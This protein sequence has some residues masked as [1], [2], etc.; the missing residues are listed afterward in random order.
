MT[1]TRRRA[2]R[3]GAAALLIAA[4]AGLALGE[5]L[6][7]RYQP[8]QG[9]AVTYRGE[10]S[11][12]AVL[13]VMGEKTTQ[14]IGVAM[15]FTDRIRAVRGEN[16]VL[17]RAFRKM[18]LA[19][20]GQKEDAPDEVLKQERSYTLDPQGVV[21]AATTGDAN[22]NPL[23]GMGF[24][25]MSL[26]LLP[27]VIVP[28]PEA[29]VSVGDSWDASESL[30]YLGEESQGLKV[31]ATTTLVSVYESEGMQVALTQTEWSAEGDLEA[32]VETRGQ[33]PAGAP[34]IPMP[35]VSVKFSGAVL[36]SSRVDD[37]CVLG[38][39]SRVSGSASASMGEGMS[40]SMQVR[41]WTS[42]LEVAG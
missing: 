2:L 17:E 13:T 33:P 27:I 26:D 41:D 25:P 30:V 3:S 14:K 9:L 39:K 19:T 31:T 38:R 11:G 7:L 22:G 18:T 12:T 29:A 8:E 24:D 21:L 10:A 23:S 15:E 40:F 1:P 34:P 32:K 36:Q 20:D 4:L 16:R 35:K 6:T 37:G 28:F 5:A 42:R